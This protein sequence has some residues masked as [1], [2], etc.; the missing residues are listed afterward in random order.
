MI[1]SGPTKSNKKKF[2]FFEII[3]ES[4]TVPPEE[5]EPE[6]DNSNIPIHLHRLVV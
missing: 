4:S 2:Q 3:K 1:N 6:E 5:P